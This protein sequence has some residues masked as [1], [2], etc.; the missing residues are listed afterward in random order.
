MGEVE[1]AGEGR[2]DGGNR[3]VDRGVLEGKV[4]LL[5][6]RS[7]ERVEGEVGARVDVWVIEEVP[8]WWQRRKELVYGGNP[9]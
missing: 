6:E 3:R 1:V 4:A 5:L 7:V 9:C 2:S 8:K